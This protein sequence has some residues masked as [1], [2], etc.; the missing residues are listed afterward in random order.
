M[1]RPRNNRLNNRRFPTGMTLVELLMVIA[2]MTILMAVAIPMIRPAFQN[3]QLRE[4]SRQVNAFFAGAKARAAGT[5]RPVGVWIE[6][7]APVGDPQYSVQLYLAEISPNYT[8][9]VLGARATV[10]SLGGGVG[11]LYFGDAYGQNL[12]SNPAVLGQLVAPGE[13]FFIRFDHKGP[14]YTCTRLATGYEITLPTGAVP[15]GTEHPP[16][17]VGPRPGLT[18]EITRSPSKSIVSPLTLPGDSVVDLTVSGVGVGSTANVF[19]NALPNEPIVIMFTPSGQTS[20]VFVNNIQYIAGGSIYLLIG[21]RAKVLSPALAASTDDAELSNLADLTNLWVTI[22][23]RTGAITTEDNAAT[24]APL[25]LV[26][27]IKAAREFARG[28]RQKGG[29]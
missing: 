23:N 12:V 25:T 29:R 16:A 3:R 22:N 19:A 9:D 21:R 7:A 18:Y 10:E 14:L 11:Q 26:E 15:R 24:F 6:A 1:A 13:K 2:I 4:A 20:S 28:S 27:R 17:N 8:G 5:G